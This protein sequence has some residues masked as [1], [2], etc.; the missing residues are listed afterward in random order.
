MIMPNNCHQIILTIL[1]SFFSNQSL[2]KNVY[3]NLWLSADVAG[4]VVKYDL[5]SFDK[6]PCG[7]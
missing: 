6:N 4:I 3:I 7:N 2:K 5:W 1:A